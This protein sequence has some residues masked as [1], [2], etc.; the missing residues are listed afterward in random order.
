[1]VYGTDVRFLEERA[2]KVVL[3]VEIAGVVELEEV[4]IKRLKS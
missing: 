1:M 4:W 2:D 3:K